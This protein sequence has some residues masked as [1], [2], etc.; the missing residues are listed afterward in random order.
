VNCTLVEIK[1]REG[2]PGSCPRQVFRPAPGQSR[3]PDLPHATVSAEGSL[4]NQHHA[5]AL[6]NRERFF[7]LRLVCLCEKGC[8]SSLTGPFCGSASPQIVAQRRNIFEL[9]K[10]DSESRKTLEH[11]HF[12][13]LHF[14]ILEGGFFLLKNPL[15]IFVSVKSRSEK[16]FVVT[17]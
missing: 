14:E 3:H 5:S 4:A 6:L 8:Y 2:V 1:L 10:L 17:L 9:K 16:C 15:G 7:S 12:T 13:Y 11:F